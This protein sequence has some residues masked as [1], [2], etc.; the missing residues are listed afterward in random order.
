MADPIMNELWKAKD[1][2]AREHGYDVD[3]LVA[4]LDERRAERNQP[5]ADLSARPKSEREDRMA[6]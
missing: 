1:A 2:I 5:E 4:Y 6:T 3:A